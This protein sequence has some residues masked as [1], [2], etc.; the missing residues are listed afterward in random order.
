MRPLFSVESL[1]T[2]LLRTA[3]SGE[4]QRVR[5]LSGI[6]SRMDSEALPGA[7]EE[8]SGEKDL[9]LRRLEL[10]AERHGIPLTEKGAQGMRALIEE[11]EDRILNEE[12]ALLL[13]LALADFLE[14]SAHD[15]GATYRS[16]R[17][18]SSARDWR[19]AKALLEANLEDE[20][21]RSIE[22]VRWRRS[23]IRSL[24]DNPRTLA[25]R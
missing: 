1:F 17:A 14:K 13:D 10:I 23:R 6:S 24:S 12:D 2:R 9:H 22:V 7:L 25:R 4:T 8:I 19:Q 18:L 16:A 11:A 5:F 20:E 21:K 3:Y 15:L